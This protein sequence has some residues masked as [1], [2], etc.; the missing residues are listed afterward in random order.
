MGKSM[1]AKRPVSEEGH[2]YHINAKPGDIPRYVLLPG[3]PDRVPK[4][5]EIWDEYHV[6]AR[7][8]EYHS[9][10]GRVGN[11]DIGAVSTGIGAPSASIAV[12]ELAAIGVDTL[13][14]VGST[15]ALS[16]H[17]QCGDLIINSGAIRF[18]GTTPYYIMPEY[19]AI[20]H[21]EVVCALIQACES[22]G[23]TYHVGVG[24]S[25]SS[26]Y[27]GQGR[28]G[29]KNYSQAWMD[30]LI[31][32][33]Q[34]ANVLNLEMET[35]SILTLSSLYDLR[36]GSICTVFA[37]RVT[38]T[39]EVVGE[40]RAI[41]AASKAV[42]ILADWDQQKKMLNKVYFYPSLLNSYQKG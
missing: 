27:T 33:L 28:P 14:R 16:E 15:G 1:D 11:T 12:E 9:I 37:N 4:I 10:C 17:I 2:Q 13:I 38:N 26:F 25:T 8:R 6:V 41:E 34:K 5:G 40:N 39:F 29:Y 23:F 42:E 30:H 7:H 20:A 24:A 21:Y 32:D 35:A 18:D 36:A 19:P 31:P 3:D 22:L